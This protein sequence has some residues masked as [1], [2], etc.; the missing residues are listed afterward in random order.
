MCLTE[1]H[2]PEPAVVSMEGWVLATNTP[3]GVLLGGK[4]QAAWRAADQAWTC[5][6]DRALA[7]SLLMEDRPLWIV[8]CY[9]PTSDMAE[10]RAHFFVSLRTY[11]VRRQPALWRSGAATGT[12][13]WAG[14]VGE[15]TSQNS[16]GR[17]RSACAG[18]RRPRESNL[19]N[20]ARSKGWRSPTRF[21]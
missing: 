20:G 13:T 3:C 10:A 8:F 4:A 19:A 5:V 9:A 6:G 1:L 12:A 2:S 16:V 21:V 7:V 14:G 11:D 18:P 17:D 15:T